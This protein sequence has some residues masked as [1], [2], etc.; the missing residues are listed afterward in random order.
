MVEP[1][2]QVNNTTT[3]G[4]GISDYFSKNKGVDTTSSFV[5]ILEVTV[6]GIRNGAFIIH[7]QGV[8]DL[9]FKILGTLEH[10]SD[11]VDPTGTN[12]DDKG[13]IVLTTSSIA[14]TIKPSIF[15]LSDS[16]TKIIIQIKHTTATTKVDVYYRG[17]N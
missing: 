16:Y 12:D 14:T 8:G 5:T 10:P 4:I 2:A 11:I 13:W 15:S 1:T 7:N 3:F 9:D 17:E 6:R